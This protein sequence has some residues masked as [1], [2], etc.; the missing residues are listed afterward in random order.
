MDI[1][2]E[3]QLETAV[4]IAHS[5]FERGKVSGSTANISIR[6]GDFIYISGSGTSFGTL[7]KEQFSTLLL[8]GTHVEGIK[9]SKEYPL[10]AMIYRYKRK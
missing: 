8:D 6:I 7:E 2:T 10:H 3:R 4:E 5:L 9:P 1:I